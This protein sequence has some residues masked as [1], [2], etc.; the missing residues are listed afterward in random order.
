MGQTTPWA[1]LGAKHRTTKYRIQPIIPL[2]YCSRLHLGPTWVPNTELQNTEYNLS[3]LFYIAAD[4]TLGQPGCQTQNYKIQNTT[5][6]TSPILQQTTPWAHLGAK[7]RTTKYRI[8]PIIPLLYC[9][10]LHLGPTWVPNTEL[11]NTEYN[12][13]YLS[14]IAADYTLG[15]P[16]C[17][18][19]N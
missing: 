9:S 14:Y 3:Y 5:Y 13:L 19:Q 18:T 12:L 1:H 11:Q 10:R 8:Q 2:L 7:H 15:P 6:Y 16:G 17:Q 4:Y